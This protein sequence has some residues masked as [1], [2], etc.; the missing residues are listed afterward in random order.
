MWEFVLIHSK[1]HLQDQALMLGKKVFVR[2]EVKTQ[3]CNSVEFFDTKLNKPCVY[4]PHFVHRGAFMLEQKKA[5]HYEYVPT[6][7]VATNLQWS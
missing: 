4:G 1:E 7:N 5:F 3:S 2:I 6:K